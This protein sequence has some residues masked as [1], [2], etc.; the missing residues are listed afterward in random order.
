VHAFLSSGVFGKQSAA[1]GAC[2]GAIMPALQNPGV[3]GRFGFRTFVYA[4]SGL[5]YSAVPALSQY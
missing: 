1:Y 4:A 3:T 2:E 5:N